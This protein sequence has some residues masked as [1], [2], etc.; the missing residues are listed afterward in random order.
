MDGT[1]RARRRATEHFV[2][3]TVKMNKSRA[4]NR[5]YEPTVSLSI[6]KTDS[7]SRRSPSPLA[8]LFQHSANFQP[9]QNP[10]LWRRMIR[11]SGRRRVPAKHNIRNVPKRLSGNLQSQVRRDSH[12]IPLMSR[13]RNNR[14]ERRCECRSTGPSKLPARYKQS[15]LYHYDPLEW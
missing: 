12:P 1:I 6:T 9:S 11:Q 4:T 15:M 10:V 5:I 3:A 13:A 2:S 14:C 7:V 8:M